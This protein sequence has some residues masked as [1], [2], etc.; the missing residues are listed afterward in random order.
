[1]TLPPAPGERRQLAEITELLKLAWPLMVAQ[2]GYMFMG[3]VDT[4]I[5][6]R[7]SPLHMAAVA[8]GSGFCSVIMVFGIGAGMGVEPLI[9]QAHGAGEVERTRRWLWQALWL[10]AL[11][12]VPMSLAAWALTYVFE[13]AG[14]ADDIAGVTRGYVIAR[15]VGIPFNCWAVVQRSYLSNVGRPKAALAAIVVANIVN[16][17]LDLALVLGWFGVPALGAVGCGWATSACQA[18]I[19]IVQGLSIR[20]L[21]DEATPGR[22]HTIVRPRWSKMMEALRLGWPIGGHLCIEVGIFT[23]VA[24]LVGRL[25][26]IPLAAHNIAITMASFT[27]LIVVGLSSATTARVGFHIGS[28]SAGMARRAGFLG[29]AL[30]ASFMAVT[31][32]TFI[33]A[34]GPIARIFTIDPEVQALGGSLLRIAGA[35]AIVDGIQVVATGA[36]RGTGETRWPFLAN[37]AAH[38][39]IGLPCALFFALELQMGARGYWWG[40]TVGLA[41]VAGAVATRFWVVSHRPIERLEHGATIPPPVDG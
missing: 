35:F 21:W 5:V 29:I 33:F 36:L 32:A 25:G 38:W 12:T 4:A 40:L 22:R 18:L 15:L 24:L 6:G 11:L 39:L 14:I 7:V 1:M 13:P 30:G 26:E 37:L 10:V 27:F 31:G 34:G 2:G 9:G 17:V 3:V 28:G 19:A 23:L 16:V 41:L 8:L 20:R